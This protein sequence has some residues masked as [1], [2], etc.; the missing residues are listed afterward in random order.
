[1]KVVWA[2]ICQKA[3]IDK[4]T[5]N[6]TLF[7]VIEEITAPANPPVIEQTIPADARALAPTIFELVVL[8]KRNDIGV[9]ETGRSRIQLLA[10]NGEAIADQ[11]VEGEVDLNAYKRLRQRITFP[12]IPYH[13]DGLQEG[14]YMIRIEKRERG[15]DWEL[16]FQLPLEISISSD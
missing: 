11:P 13:E 9:G 3:V 6:V 8:W 7:N 14:E 12:G 4:D 10:P 16:A 15:S 1:M 5:N 2:V